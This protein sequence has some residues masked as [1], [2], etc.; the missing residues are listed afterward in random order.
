MAWIREGVGTLPRGPVFGRT[1]GKTGGAWFFQE[2]ADIGMQ[3]S[4]NIQAATVLTFTTRT[5]SSGVGKNSESAFGSLIPAGASVFLGAS[6]S[7]LSTGS[8]INAGG[9]T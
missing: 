1:H 4:L 9:V 6:D 5:N 2:A 3:L 8:Q 7:S